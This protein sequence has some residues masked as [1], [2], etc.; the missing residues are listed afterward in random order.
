MY[1]GMILTNDL[2]CWVE[3]I[4]PRELVMR[5]EAGEEIQIIDVRDKKQYKEAYVDGA[6]S[7]PLSELRD[8]AEELDKEVTTVTYCN[9]GTTGNAAQ[10]LLLNLGFK[11]VYNLAGGNQNYQWQKKIDFGRS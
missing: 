10:N 7:I 3:T 5:Q 11:E 2:N 8:Q 1:T 4:M 9:K 6:V